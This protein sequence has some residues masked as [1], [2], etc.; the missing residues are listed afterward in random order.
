MRLPGD[1]QL[2]LLG[3]LGFS[4]AVS[5]RVAQSA[6][7]RV[8]WPFIIRTRLVLAFGGFLVVS[9]PSR[10]ATLQPQEGRP[11]GTLETRR[12]TRLGMFQLQLLL[13]RA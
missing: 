12:N 8:L 11:V 13:N 10:Q 2:G 9:P 5:V 4:A 7:I 6:G 3:L 1:R